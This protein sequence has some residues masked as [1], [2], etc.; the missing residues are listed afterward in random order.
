MILEHLVIN[1]KK[2][3]HKIIL[4][5]DSAGANLVLALLSH[6]K[7][8]DQSIPRLNLSSPLQA[9][10]LIS[11]WISFKDDV[12]SMTD[13][14]YNDIVTFTAATRWAEEYLNEKLPF[15]SSNEYTEPRDAAP[16]WWTGLPVRNV[17]SMCSEDECLIDLIRDFFG[18][19]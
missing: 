1:L 13:N 14:K 5:G 19:V 7:H 17:I 4:M 9:A 18:Q 15:P 8:P 10:V 2:D 6:L 16:E 11:A 3:P 12:P